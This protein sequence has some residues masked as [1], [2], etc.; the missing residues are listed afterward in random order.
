[1]HNC[2]HELVAALIW[3]PLHD[4]CMTHCRDWRET[5]GGLLP[6]SEHSPGCQNF[7]QE[8]F[9]KVTYSTGGSCIMEWPSD[10]EWTDLALDDGDEPP[11]LEEIFMT[12]DQFDRLG[13]FPGP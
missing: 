5:Q 10:T 2:K 6:P 3:M 9:C 4:C 1:M 11:V 7:R 12:R 8:R 13:E